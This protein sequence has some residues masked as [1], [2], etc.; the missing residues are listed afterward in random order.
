MPDKEVS[1]SRRGVYYDLTLSPYVVNTAYGDCFRFSSPKKMEIY[2]REE[3]KE[4][5]RLQKI[6][7]RNDMQG[8]LPEE[9]VVL[10]ERSVTR[11]LYER[12]E[13]K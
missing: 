5:D 2:E 1:V 8:F 9:I 7:D 3:P 12:V 10:L 11:A 13:D 6:L 4:L